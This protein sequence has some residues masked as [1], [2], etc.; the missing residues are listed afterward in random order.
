MDIFY[1]HGFNSGKGSRSAR[2]LSEYFG[3]VTELDW[4]CS[5]PFMNNLESM[6]A[7]LDGIEPFTGLIVGNSTGAVY[8]SVLALRFNLHMVLVNPVTFPVAQLNDFT[9]RQWNE[10]LK[11]EWDFDAD[12]LASYSAYDPDFVKKG[13]F[14]KMVIL[15]RN[16]ATLDHTIAENFWR[17]SAK[18]VLV[19][20]DHRISDY[21]NLFPLMEQIYSQDIC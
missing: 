19:D 8:A 14:K 6:S 5:K 9:G 4:D 21:T 20:E 2:L 1:V 18:I 11:L 13:K 12:T 15:G 16:D 7:R 10:V 3:D 17:G